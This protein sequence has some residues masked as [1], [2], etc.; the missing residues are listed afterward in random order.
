MK[1][2]QL[3]LI[4]VLLSFGSTQA[5]DFTDGLFQYVYVTDING[6]D[7]LVH[8]TTAIGEITIPLTAINS[9]NSKTYNVT[10]LRNYFGGKDAA[11]IPN[12]TK[13]ILQEGIK[14]IGQTS[15][16]NN[17]A[18]AA[19]KAITSFNLPSTLTSVHTGSYD[20][21]NLL[22]LTDIYSELATPFT[23]TEND[24]YN[25]RK[26]NITLHVPV[27]SVNAYVNAGWTNFK[28]IVENLSGN[29]TIPESPTI[30]SVTSGESQAIVA[31]SAPSSDGG[32]PITSYTVTSNPGGISKTVSSSPIYVTGLTNGTSYTFTVIA[33]NVVG[34]SAPSV[35]SAAVVPVS[36]RIIP[37]ATTQLLSICQSSKTDLHMINSV[38][39]MDYSAAQ[40]TIIVYK[41][42]G[43]SYSY[44]LSSVD[45]VGV[46]TGSA[47]S[48]S[49]KVALDVTRYSVVGDG[50]TNNRTNLLTAISEARSANANL[51]FPNG[52][53]LC[54][55]GLNGQNIRFIGQNRTNTILKETALTNEHNIDG[56]DNITFQNFLVSDYGTSLTRTF[57]NCSFQTTLSASTSYIQVYS[58][59]YT[60]NANHKFINCDFTYPHIWVGLYVRKYNSVYI[61][62]CYFNGHATHNIRIDQPYAVT[63]TVSVL[64]NTIFGGTTGIFIAPSQGIP[65]VGGLIQNNKLYSQ[66]EESIAMD[67]FGNDAGVIPV[68]ANGPIA[69]ASNDSNG[70]LVVSLDSMVNS[71]ANTITVSSR[72]DWTNFY[73][74]FGANTGLDGNYVKVFNFDAAA[75]TLTLDTVF[76]ASNII[77]T[78]DA[79]VESGFFNWT[80]RGNSVSGTLGANNTYGTALSMYLNAFG[81]LVENNTVT[82]CAHGINIAGGNMVNGTRTL[83]YN[84]IV[85]YNTFSDCD[86]YDVSQP[87]EDYGVVRIISYWGG[88][89]PLQFRNQFTNNTVNGGRI[90]IERQRNYIETGNIY[91]NVTRLAVDVQ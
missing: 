11:N 6:T 51:Y 2:I 40:N 10:G 88:T 30:T 58:G 57:K 27:G 78:G 56:A 65:M 59:M 85:R 1:R 26:P 14:T 3:F 90:F 70:R 67:G 83:A 17:D 19:L 91:N 73:F 80:V 7:V 34:N 38:D 79:G 41:K 22:A 52:I 77:L 48:D 13:L 86:R 61:D 82:N 55:G 12:R 81:T 28:A 53:Y 63:S 43:S 49:L 54:T 84:N 75:N 33:T 76:S 46:I 9:G 39:S 37:S 20:F 5:Q 31:F 69:S 15:I 16:G 42:G 29:A 21:A 25:T 60:L 72:T 68:I 4:T 23:V 35:A 44:N 62:N 64:N 47:W 8:T 24:F 45:S 87:S 50:V 36:Q 32:S 66:D 74:A 89:G 71:S 18:A